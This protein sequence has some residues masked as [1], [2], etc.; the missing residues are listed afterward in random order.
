MA[1]AYPEAVC[2]RRQ[3][4]ETLAGKKIADVSP[5]DI[6]KVEGPWRFGS[7]DQP[8]SVFR[9]RLH[10]GTIAGVE[11]IANTVFL[12]TSTGYA[13]AL[14]YLSGRVLY[15]AAGEKLPARRCLTV[16]F[17]DDGHLSVSISLWGL[18]R[19]LDDEERAAYLA[20]W[21]GQVVEPTS[22][23]YT[24][25]G[26]RD[27]VSKIEDPRLSTKKFL[28]AF[29]PGHYLS[30]IDSGYA[31]EILH[32]ARI[33]PKRKLA[34][35]SLPELKACYQNVN[36]VAE[37]AINEG[38]RCSEVDLFGHH[39]GF[40]LHVCRERSGQPCLACGA[41]IVKFKFEGGTCY[42]CPACQPEGE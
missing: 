31:I 38:G 35:L 40:L 11:S 24:W 17:A 18:I 36:T 16:R 29:E 39:G 32:R 22:A 8:P 4:A 28:H 34:S 25:K 6:T 10:G 13:L 5:L 30:G 2:L 12:N 23:V 37:E 1:M 14:G 20:K 41:P 19:V 33:H 42:A 26:F 15:H 7:I 3:M 9:D 21:Y 27:A